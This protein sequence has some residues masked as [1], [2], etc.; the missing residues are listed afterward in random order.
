MEAF[1]RGSGVSL[2]SARV[3][4]EP[5]ATVGDGDGVGVG[6]GIGVGLDVGV[7]VRVGVG[8]AVE[9]G[10]GVGTP[11]GAERCDADCGVGTADGDVIRLIRKAFGLADRPTG[12]SGCS[13][14]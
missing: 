12:V 6:E 5:L 8:V 13:E 4:P 9:M 1:G 7:G 3:Q 11:I 2:G 14:P 10:R